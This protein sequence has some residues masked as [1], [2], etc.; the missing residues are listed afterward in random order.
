[1]RIPMSHLLEVLEAD[2]YGGFCL[3]CG[4]EVW[5][6][7]PDAAN[8]LCDHCGDTQVYGAETVLLLEEYE[9]GA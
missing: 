4:R 3:S 1:M 5:G 9:E 7:E 8:Y 6:V 2:N